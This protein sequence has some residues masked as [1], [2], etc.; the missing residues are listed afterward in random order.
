MFN[1]MIFKGEKNPKLFE[2]ELDI[3]GTFINLN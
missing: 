3:Y 2:A 1:V